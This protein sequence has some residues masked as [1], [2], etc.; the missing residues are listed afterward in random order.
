[1]KE[2]E[3]RELADKFMLR[4]PTGMRERI[5][6]TAILEGRSMNSEILATLE[7]KYPPLV[8]SEIQDPA[9]KM[10]L[11]LAGRI[12]RNKPKP[13]SWRDQQATTYERIA[14]DLLTR[15]SKIQEKDNGANENDKK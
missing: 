8:S 5:K 13:N 9:A 3:H 14:K 12:R 15:L 11:W 10:L 2:T 6:T 7:A 4:L 1:M